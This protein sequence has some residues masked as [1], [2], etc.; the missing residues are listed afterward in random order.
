MDGSVQKTG[1]IGFQ[2]MG[3]TGL[4]NIV[5]RYTGWY[6]IPPSGV[7]RGV[8]GGVQGCSFLGAPDPLPFRGAPSIQSK[9][10][11]IHIYKYRGHTQKYL[12]HRDAHYH[13]P[14]FLLTHTHTP[15]HTQTDTYSKIAIFTNLTNLLRIWPPPSNFPKGPHYVCYA[16][17][18]SRGCWGP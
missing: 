3:A 6:N 12:H 2:G 8:T 11:F 10:L 15:T 16:P 7:A 5:V 14:T 9:Y 13:P 18:C 17:G 4:A 1:C